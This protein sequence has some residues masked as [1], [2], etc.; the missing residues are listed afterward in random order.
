MSVFLAMVEFFG[1]MFLVA[2]FL[3]TFCAIALTIAMIVAIYTVELHT[4]PKG[5]TALDWLS[6]FLYLPQVMYVLLF[7]WLVVIGPGRHSIDHYLVRVLRLESGT[8]ARG[9]RHTSAV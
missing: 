7:G 2:G 9:A 5:L 4:I 1:G 3:S 8:I 6:Y